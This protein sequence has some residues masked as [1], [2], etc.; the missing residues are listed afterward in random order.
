MSGLLLCSD[1]LPACVH[2]IRKQR[3]GDWCVLPFQNVFLAA[4][5]GWPRRRCQRVAFRTRYAWGRQYSSGREQ[6]SSM[7]RGKALPV[8]TTLRSCFPITSLSITFCC[9]RVVVRLCEVM[10]VA[11]NQYSSQLGT[12]SRCK[13]LL[14]WSVAAASTVSR[15]LF[16]RLASFAVIM[17]GTVVYLQ[18]STSAVL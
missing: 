10:R 9:D 5:C 6:W 7:G 16:A 15:S 3:F 2:H 13:P 4:P 12:K 1:H 18:R 11:S 8:V 14:K 17:G